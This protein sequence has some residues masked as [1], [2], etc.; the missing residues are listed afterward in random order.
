VLEQSPLLGRSS[1]R[2]RLSGSAAGIGEA[3][4]RPAVARAQRGHLRRVLWVVGARR[5]ASQPS[6]RTELLHGNAPGSDRR[7]G[8][9]RCVED[10][11][12]TPVETVTVKGTP[13]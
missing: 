12:K 3:R 13:G 9:H 11:R 8:Q 7:G 4:R 2:Q 10:Q 6:V 1:E 5:A